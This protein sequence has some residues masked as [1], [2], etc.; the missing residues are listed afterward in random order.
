MK[1]DGKSLLEEIASKE[2]LHKSWKKLN[3]TNK[4]SRGLSN[5]TIKDFD[6]NLDANLDSISKALLSGKYNF[7][8]VRAVKI[9]KN[10]SPDF[11]PLRIGE[12]RDRIVQKALSIK[13]DQLLSDTFNLDN[14]CSFAYRK[15]KNVENAITKMVE[16]YNQGFKI[17]LEADIVKFFDSVLKSDLLQQIQKSLPDTSINSLLVS[18]TNQEIGNSETFSKEEFEK[19]FSN[20]EEGI[21]QGNAL[22]PLLANIYLAGFDKRMI[23]SKIKMIRYADDFIIMCE[24][25]Q[26]AESALQIAKEELEIKLSL[27]I[28][29]LGNSMD[30]N[31]KTRIVNPMMHKFSFLSIRFDGKRCWVKDKKVKLIIDKIEQITSVKESQ[32]NL[33]S[34][35]LLPILNSLKNTVE[36]WI[37]AYYFVDLSYDLIEIDKHIN[38]CLHN[39]LNDL[40]FTLDK[41]SLEK[42]SFKGKSNEIWAL[43]KQ[44]RANIGIPYCHE[45]WMKLRSSASG[46]NSWNADEKKAPIKKWEKAL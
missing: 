24:T 2:F 7:S 20:S 44:Q 4:F 3:K 28:H 6:D 18:A 37:A 5:I 22:S 21:P 34:K 13:L 17:I 41:K 1:N 39:L 9:P 15:N 16:Y 38:R 19:Y 45:L 33:K 14:E 36:G 8:G 29:P 11:R 32:L 43:N 40:G 26:I 31:A 23:E 46:I 12:I 42:I 30:E 35:A 10:N 25:Q 27:T